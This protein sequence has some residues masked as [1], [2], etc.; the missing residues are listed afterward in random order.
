MS[1]NKLIIFTRF[2]EPGSVKTRLIPALG[3]SGAAE[4]QKKT[5][6]HTLR[7]ASVFSQKSGTVLQ[8]HFDGGSLESM[9]NWLGTGYRF[10]DQGE[11]DLGERM[12][13]AF[14]ESFIEG[15]SRVIIVGTD[16]PELTAAHARLAFSALDSHDLVIVPAFDGGYCL[17]GM[18]RM[19]PE[20]F[21]DIEWGSDAVFQFTIDRAARAGLSI[22]VLKPLRD[23]D[24]PEDIPIWNSV[25]SRFISI[26][27]PTLNEEDNLAGTLDRVGE[28]RDSEVIVVD[29]GSSDGTVHIAENWGAKVITAEAG[30]GGQMDAGA[31]MAS[32]DILLFLHADTL[33]PTD[34]STWIR[35]AFDDPLVVA[36][37]FR[38]KVEPAGPFLKWIELTVDWRIRLFHLP[39]GDQAI[40]VRASLFRQV[41]G[42][43]GA[44]LMEDL[45]LIRRLKKLGRIKYIK[46]PVVTSARRYE[47]LGPFRTTMINKATLLR[48]YLKVPHQK[49]EKSYY[50][51]LRK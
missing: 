29:G 51:F 9:K 13:R 38:W 35:K 4:L 17:L 40:F 15:S 44:P 14:R 43:E 1:G 24:T 34:Y 26:I 12:S 49:L 21:Q 22:E 2:P 48:Y 25:S 6:E 36:G 5:A 47:A 37:A 30:R 19:V 10:V 20:L 18:R 41:G 31:E 11:G 46:E 3:D 28:I 45:D 7:W 33:L 8:I 16:A 50:K 23:I 42:F 39:Y 27:M 32:G